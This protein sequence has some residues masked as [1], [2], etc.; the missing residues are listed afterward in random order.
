LN[1]G[2]A[3]YLNSL[4]F[5]ALAANSLITIA[6]P[7]ADSVVVTHVEYWSDGG[8]GIDLLL[9]PQ[10]NTN[11]LDVP[12]SDSAD[13]QVSLDNKESD[14]SDQNLEISLR[15]ALDQKKSSR[16]ALVIR[17]SS[18]P[19]FQQ[20]MLEFLGLVV[21]YTNEEDRVSV[22]IWNDDIKPYQVRN[23]SQKTPLAVLNDISR[24]SS[25]APLSASLSI[26]QN[27]ING[28]L[29]QIADEEPGDLQRSRSIVLIGDGLTGMDIS[30]GIRAFVKTIY[31][32][33]IQ[34]GPETAAIKLSQWIK[35]NQIK[36]HLRVALCGGDKALLSRLKVAGVSSLDFDSVSGSIIFGR[37]DCDV[38]DILNS[39][40]SYPEKMFFTFNAKQ[41]KRF[42]KIVHDRSKNDFS[43][44][45]SFAPDAKIYKS[46]AHLRGQGTLR[47]C[48]KKSYTVNISANKTHRLITGS[49][50]NEYFLFA[51]CSDPHYLLNFTVLN[52]WKSLDLFSL[53]YRFIELIIDG[54]SRGI[55]LLMEKSPEALYQDNIAISSVVRTR[56]RSRV[57]T[58]E[59]KYSSAT[60]TNAVWDL[61]FSFSELDALDD[62]EQVQLLEKKLDIDQFM[63]HLASTS[64]LRNGDYFD[65]LWY[66][67][68]SVYRADGM[69]GFQ[70]T[71]MKWD[72]AEVFHNCHFGNTFTIPDPWG[73]TY[74][75]E[76]RIG[77]TIIKNPLLFDRYAVI[78]ENL[79]NSE[80]GPQS[81]SNAILGTRDALI[82]RL[83]GP[84]I[85]KHMVSF[86]DQPDKLASVEEVHNML[87]S[88]TEEIYGWYLERRDQLLKNLEKYRSGKTQ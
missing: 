73:L 47:H 21:G 28:K 37:S 86:H 76:S 29:H 5:L 49:D 23:I 41:L 78:L 44:G 8:I 54:E 18:D 35:D 68:N 3:R 85:I 69:P 22:F 15:S 61:F 82:K 36:G 75:V 19:D 42:N 66:Q 57:R 40:F 11:A 62:F 53:D 45:V 65:E 24:L 2:M 27:R 50:T 9:N 17:P 80:L 4:V 83:N 43:L 25:D 59:A 7:A 79:L 33:E 26:D 55:Y 60:K 58:L 38:N 63:R 64:V 84:D 12:N 46:D 56:F 39:R 87:N 34:A 32:Q 31:D 72:P 48:Q 67:Q 70:Y 13:F 1:P 51:M 20:N 14:P 52:L 30:S 6:D 81:F 74:C 77:A 16:I 88:K 10:V 71:I